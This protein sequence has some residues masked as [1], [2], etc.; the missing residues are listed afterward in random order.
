MTVRTP[1]GEAISQ[2]T[3]AR[4]YDAVMGRG[5]MQR[6][7]RRIG[8]QVAQMLPCGGRILDIGTGPGY[9]AIEVARLLG[10]SAEITGIDASEA[11]LSVA[12]ENSRDAG[13]EARVCWLTADAAHMPFGDDEFDF[14][15]SNGSLCH[16]RDPVGV[17]AEISRV[18]RPAGGYQVSAP[19]RLTAPLPRVAAWLVGA[20]LPRSFR[21]QFWTSINAAYTPNELAGMLDQSALGGWTIEREFI[22]LRIFRNPG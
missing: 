1:K 16:W 18:L 19:Q 21:A 6:E 9:V 2:I 10:A 15:V 5:L 20:S 8:R 11:M 14:V 4:R 12:A 7:Y 3:Q 17:F 13:V 22:A